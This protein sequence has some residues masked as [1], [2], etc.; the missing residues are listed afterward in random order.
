MQ[1]GS[2]ARA[3]I[4]VASTNSTLSMAIA[5][6]Y[7]FTAKFVEAMFKSSHYQKARNNRKVFVITGHTKHD[8]RQKIL[9]QMLN[10]QHILIFTIKT[11]GMGWNL[12]NTPLI[13][14]MEPHWNPQIE[15]QAIDRVYRLYHNFDKVFSFQVVVRDT[16]GKQQ[17]MSVK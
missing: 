17:L 10:Q 2:K 16:V 15:N 12:V 6:Q 3:V 5:T 14:I 4:T 1:L 8:D 7:V 11:G 9:D 13:F